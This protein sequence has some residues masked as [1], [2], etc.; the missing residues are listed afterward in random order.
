[1]ELDAFV[2]GQVYSWRTTI[3]LTLG[4]LA[5]VTYCRRNLDWRKSLRPTLTV[6]P[7]LTVSTEAEMYTFS[8]TARLL[9]SDLLIR[10]GLGQ[11]S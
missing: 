6:I 7:F 2:A 3:L 1:M 9:R 10:S 8:S 4:L 11:L 5:T